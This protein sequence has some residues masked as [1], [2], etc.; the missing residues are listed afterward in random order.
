MPTKL[1]SLTLL[2]ALLMITTGIIHFVRTSS[3]LH[4]VPESFPL[5]IFIIQLSGLIE[6]AAGIGLL[7]PATRYAAAWIV[8]LL[9]LG[10]LPLHIWD[11]TRIRPAMGSTQ[12]AWLRLALQFV[13]IAWAWYIKR[14]Y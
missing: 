1:Q 4:I 12:A 3:Y 6:L 7:I 5:R 10:F 14:E 11:V 8:L 2:M 13:L 9:M